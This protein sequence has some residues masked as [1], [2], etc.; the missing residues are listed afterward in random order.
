MLEVHSPAGACCWVPMTWNAHS[1]TSV[2]CLKDRQT[3]LQ[4]VRESEEPGQ[5]RHQNTVRLL[6]CIDRL[7]VGPLLV[8]DE[9][10]ERVDVSRACIASELSLFHM[11]NRR[12]SGDKESSRQ[13]GIIAKWHMRCLY[14]KLIT[15]VRF[16]TM[17]FGNLHN[18]DFRNVHRQIVTPRAKV[19]PCRLETA[20]CRAPWCKAEHKQRWWVLKSMKIV[21]SKN[22]WNYRNIEFIYQKLNSRLRKFLKKRV[23]ASP[24]SDSELAWLN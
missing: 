19:F 7:N 12:Q 2:Q 5:N 24:E 13:S 9:A 22:E 21:R 10:H 16:E 3:H 14:N 23:N 17:N 4:K 15:N 18:V 20:A 1:S 6:P 8:L 11:I